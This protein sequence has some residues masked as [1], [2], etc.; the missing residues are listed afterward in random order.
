M[1]VA[2]VRNQGGQAFIYWLGV[3]LSSALVAIAAALGVAAFGFMVDWYSPA[4]F[5][6][7]IGITVVIVIGLGITR[8]LQTPPTELLPAG[9]VAEPGA[10]ADRS[11]RGGLPGR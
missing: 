1:R 8:G 2:V 7:A 4:A 3:L 10:A 5:I 11:N 6:L 9:R